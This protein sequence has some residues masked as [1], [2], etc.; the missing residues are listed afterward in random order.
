MIDSYISPVS[1]SKVDERMEK[2][3]G[4]GRERRQLTPQSVIHGPRLSIW[5][6]H[7]PLQ[8][9]NFLFDSPSDDPVSK[10]PAWKIGQELMEA[11]SEVIIGY[12]YPYSIF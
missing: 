11:K 5:Y 6:Q 9:Q 2:Q 4:N 3:R 7:T 10:D 1:L 8:S 12:F